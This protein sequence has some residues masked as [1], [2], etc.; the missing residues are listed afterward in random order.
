MWDEDHCPRP[1]WHTSSDK[2][3]QMNAKMG[4]MVPGKRWK[5]S[6]EGWQNPTGHE[7]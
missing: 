4:Y 6:V 7:W 2:I 1:E 5:P 3:K